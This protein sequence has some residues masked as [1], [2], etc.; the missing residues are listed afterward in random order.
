MTSIATIIRKTSTP[1][2]RAYFEHSGIGLPANIDWA[3][4]EPE[5]LPPALSNQCGTAWRAMIAGANE[6]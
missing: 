6:P 3:V 4:P 2:L 1:T 5:I